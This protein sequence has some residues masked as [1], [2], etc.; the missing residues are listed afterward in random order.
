MK[1]D[2]QRKGMIER[3]RLTAERVPSFF[4]FLICVYLRKSAAKSYEPF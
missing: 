2:D 1:D 3:Q 4:L